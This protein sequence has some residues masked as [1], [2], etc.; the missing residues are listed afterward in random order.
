MTP[1]LRARRLDKEWLAVLQLAENNPGGLIPLGRSSRGVLEIFSLQLR[2]TD[3]LLM[4][5]HE[6]ARRVVSTH[7]F[8]LRFPRFYP[9]VPLEAYLSEP[10]LHPNVDPGTG[11][12]CLWERTS[13]GDTAI[14]A[15]RRVQAMIA[16]K[17]YNL[18][19]IHIVQPAAAEWVLQ[20]PGIALPLR[21]TPLREPVEWRRHRARNAWETPPR[22]TRLSKLDT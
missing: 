13:P 3:G 12:L 10:L 16:W 21:H 20:Q 2:D 14:E 19:A 17:M 9:A 1:S 8:E 15:I 11:F 5:I 7:S 22:R 4:R 6:G 18:E